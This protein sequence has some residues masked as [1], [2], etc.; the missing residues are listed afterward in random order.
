[1][2]LDI[3][4]LF[5]DWTG[6][7]PR[8]QWWIGVGLLIAAV[9]V[10]AILT[11]I[12]AAIIGFGAFVVYAVGALAISYF[13]VPLAAKRFQDRGRP[14]NLA[15]IGF[16]LSILSIVV[17]LINFGRGPSLLSTIVG[18]AAFG[19]GIWYLID[20]GC[21]RG[22]VGPNQYGPDP[23]PAVG[24]PPGQYPPGEYPPGQYPQGYPPNPQ[25]YPPQ[26]QG[27]YQPNPQGYPQQPQNYP[28]N[29]P[30]PGHYPPQQ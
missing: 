23:L 17:E 15:W 27:H 9:I 10:L 14:G 5:L 8:S 19:V 28:P 25:G 11:G 30:P 20:L 3:R 12:L 2:Q 24:Y 21:L 18:L 29:Q 13:S 7:I 26:P 1:M 4:R 6:R 16:G 22:T